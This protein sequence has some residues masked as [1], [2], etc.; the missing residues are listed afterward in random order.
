MTIACFDAPGAVTQRHSLLVRV[1][2]PFRIAIYFTG[3]RKVLIMETTKYTK[4]KDLG[5]WVATGSVLLFFLIYLGAAVFF[6]YH[7]LPGTV[8]N[9][10]DVSGKS[11][12]QVEQQMI[13][14]IY[15][16]EIK[17]KARENKE[18]TLTGK[19]IKLRSIFDG[20]LEKE[21]KEQN[22]FAWPSAL[23]RERHIEVRTMVYF[24]KGALERETSKWEILDKEKM[25]QPEDARVSEYLPGEGYKIVTEK[26]GTTVK[27]KKFM[28]QLRRAILQLEDTFSLD[29]QGCYTKPKRTSGS[30]NLKKQVKVMNQFAQTSITYQFGTEEEILDGKTISAWIFVDQDGEV[31]VSQ[32]QITAYVDYLADKWDTVGKSKKLVTT[33]GTEVVIE[34]GDYGW[35]IDREKEFQ[36][37]KELILSGEVAVREPEYDRWA[38]SR[39]GNDYGDTYVEVNLGTQH[40]FYYKD[41]Q[42]L[43]ESD[44]VSG[45]DEKNWNTP[46][47]AFGLYYKERNRV[48]RGEGYASPVSFW[49]PFNGGVGFHD[50]TWRRSFGGSYYL[51]NGSHGCINL[52]YSAAKKLYDNIEAGCAVL[53]Y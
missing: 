51:R 10:I 1:R 15:S 31:N 25:K 53:V 42:L 34:D 11:V 47:G 33:Y 7:F 3:L 5:V 18:E 32:E 36:V 50:A 13:E 35:R 9:G 26:D 23:A 37:L 44:F 29:E 14:E 4:I 19:D 30:K 20:T 39:N 6:C 2:I 17:I 27:V 43:M 24:D 52:P 49:M 45:N 12:D 28:D 38:N 46:P 21:L 40:L 41:G 8:I 16:Y 22:I 48:L